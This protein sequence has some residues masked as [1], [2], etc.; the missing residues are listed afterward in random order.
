MAARRERFVTLVSPQGR[1]VR[2]LRV[3]G[4]LLVLA[5]LLVA[6]G[7]AGYFIPFSRFSIE[8]VELNQK[9]NF[10]R[11]NVDL[12]RR[13]HDMQ[14]MV[15][16]L[17]AE[18]SRLDGQHV[19]V[20]RLR[21]DTSRAGRGE[22]RAAS[23]IGIDELFS[24]VSRFEGN[25]RRYSANVQSRPGWFRDLPVLLPLDH[26]AVLAVPFGRMRDPFSGA[27]KMHQGV[28]LVGPRGC[29]VVATADGTV[30]EVGNDRKWGLRVRLNH[31]R[32]FATVYAHLGSVAVRRG[33][34]VKRG[35][36]IGT[37]GA[38]GITTGPHLHYEV[39]RN[40]TPLDPRT[41]F[42]P[43]LDSSLAAFQGLAGVQ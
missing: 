6:G 40:D 38:T 22:V 8:K 39:R 36:A 16:S 43:S 42:H 1:Q 7:F 15:R 37:L 32:G 5:G 20:E 10:E 27:E 35:D 17:Q 29:G 9:R 24:R 31:G 2:T 13:I 11:L 18:L 30:S 14:P 4:A 28:D 25:W 12:L 21:A 26:Q 33:Q 3:R 19:L 34:S 41:M 23:L